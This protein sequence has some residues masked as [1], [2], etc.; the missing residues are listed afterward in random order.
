MKKTLTTLWLAASLAL[1]WVPKANAQINKNSDETQHKIEN[2]FKDQQRV[3]P[4]NTITFE[5]AQNLSQDTIKIQ[6]IKNILKD[7]EFVNKFTNTECVKELLKVNNLNKDD[8]EKMIQDIFRFRCK[9]F[10]AVEICNK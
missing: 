10:F 8:V 4:K 6:D 7:K 2:V 9:K 1:Y 3:D 5:E